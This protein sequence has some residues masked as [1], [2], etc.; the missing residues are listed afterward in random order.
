MEKNA[1]VRKSSLM[2][3][4][5]FNIPI[6]SNNSCNNQHTVLFATHVAIS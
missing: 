3:G 2:L 6:L 4:L 1:P 5:S